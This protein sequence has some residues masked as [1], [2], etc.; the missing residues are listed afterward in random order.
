MRFRLCKTHGIAAIALIAAAASASLAGQ[1]VLKVTDVSLTQ[2]AL[3]PHQ[4]AVLTYT[5]SGTGVNA[6]GALSGVQIQFLKDS[7]PVKT[8]PITAGQPGAVAGANSVT[9]NADDIPPG[10]PYTIKVTAQGATV[11]PAGY[12]KVSNAAD[13]NLQFTNPR[14]IDVNRV[15][16]SPALGRVYVTEGA[17]GT[18]KNRI[19][20]EGVYALNPDLSPAFATVKATTADIGAL[21]PWAASAHSPFRVYV[22]PDAT[23]YLTDAS[24]AHPTVLFTD[25]DLTTFTR[26][27]ATPPA[28]GIQAASGLVTDS[29]GNQVFGDCSSLWV[30]GSGADRKVFASIQEIVPANTIW[31]YLIPAGD[32]EVSQIPTLVASPTVSGATTWYNDFVRDS[33]GNTYTTNYST[34]SIGKFDATGAWL[35]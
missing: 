26:L 16:G 25:P 18:A 19:T 14:G 30:E 34:N 31:Q 32:S 13:P 20:V 17:A 35:R 15:A 4:T 12:I 5:L 27:F 11:T 3:Y 33:D 24:D 6:S 21:G 10:G 1:L 28:G 23:V 29:S 22:G 2:V 9:L 7:V 8:V